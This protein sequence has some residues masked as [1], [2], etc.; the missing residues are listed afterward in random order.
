MTDAAH[1]ARG[2]QLCALLADAANADPEAT[3]PGPADRPVELPPGTNPA[4]TPPTA[5]RTPRRGVDT[6]G[7][8]RLTDAVAELDRSWAAGPVGSGLDT[9][10]SDGDEDDSRATG[11]RRTDLDV[12]GAGGSPLIRR[13]IERA[14]SALGPRIPR[15][16][17]A[18]ADDTSTDERPWSDS[19]PDLSPDA[20]AVLA[21]HG[22]DDDSYTAATVRERLATIAADAG[23]EAAGAATID[24]GSTGLPSLDG[25]ALVQQ[26][27]VA[28]VDEEAGARPWDL[29]RPSKREW[30]R[31]LGIAETRSLA[32]ETLGYEDGNLALVDGTETAGEPATRHRLAGATEAVVAASGP[33][34]HRS[35]TLGPIVETEPADDALGARPSEPRWRATGRA[36]EAATAYA[37]DVLG[38]AVAHLEP[39]AA[40]SPSN[41]TDTRSSPNAAGAE[42]P[43][44]ARWADKRVRAQVRTV[45]HR[46]VYEFIVPSPAALYR[47]RLA[48][49]SASGPVLF[50]PLQLSVDGGPLL[51]ELIGPGTYQLFVG[52]YGVTDLPPPPG[53]RVTASAVVSGT[54]F[55]AGTALLTDELVAPEGYRLKDA[56]PTVSDVTDLGTPGGSVTVDLG[57]ERRQ[58]EYRDGV[59]TGDR[60]FHVTLP[61]VRTVAVRVRRSRG[62]G[63]PRRR[64]GRRRP[65]RTVPHRQLRTGSRTGPTG[66]RA[67]CSLVAPGR[68]GVVRRRLTDVRRPGSGCGRRRDPTPRTRPTEPEEPTDARRRALGS[69]GPDVAGTADGR[70]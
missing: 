68:R 25:T 20:R 19:L 37:R 60:R 29:S 10:D 28:L 50:E 48:R 17:V 32:V 61:D 8:R 52:A 30:I 23:A 59:A 58:V 53:D 55:G 69:G 3:L 45:E 56:F 14:R 31:P 18:S 54:G 49:Q 26:Y 44:M 57:L 35:R 36:R 6:T 15:P 70:R 41:A 22:L 21:E 33:A 5:V 38:D 2:L 62:L 67:A 42:R 43:A 47:R 27:G 12:V 7:I 40:Q 39:E 1:L 11:T 9:M 24:D 51:P 13:G 63:R 64:R 66:P 65:L 34:W 16:E 46:L 4:P